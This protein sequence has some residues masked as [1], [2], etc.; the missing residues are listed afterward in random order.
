MVRVVLSHRAVEIE[1]PKNGAVFKVN[2]QRL[3]PFFEIHVSDNEEVM[4]LHDPQYAG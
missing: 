2:G 3:K 1:D 4:S